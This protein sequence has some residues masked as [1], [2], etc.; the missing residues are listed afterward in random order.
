MYYSYV[1]LFAI[2]IMILKSMNIPIKII[3]V[4]IGIPFFIL[5]SILLGWIDCKIGLFQEEAKRNSILNPI[6]KEILDKLESI[7]KKINN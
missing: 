1:Q 2:V 4:I 6:N 5:F 7:E 3:Y